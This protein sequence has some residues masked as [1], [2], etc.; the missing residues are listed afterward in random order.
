MLTNLYRHAQALAPGISRL[1]NRR[2]FS[3]VS[4]HQTF[5]ASLYRFQIHRGS[6]L[7]DRALRQDD[8][9]Y[10][11][12][13]EISPDGLVH[14]NITIDFSNGA[15]LM[16][17]TLFMQKV[18]RNSFDYYIDS[19]EGG[20]TPAEPHYLCIPKGTNI[21]KS[22]ILYR[23]RTSRFSLQPA[24]PMSLDNLNKELTEFYLDFGRVLDAD[25][26]LDRNPYN[27][28]YFDDQEDWMNH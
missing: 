16:P 12:G 27:E 19:V 15:V 6:T 8:W 11:D 17:N 28:A 7:Y 1:R 26:W 24:H 20:Q 3:Y 10:E 18:T 21:P 22:L 5:P 25:E 13:I 2:A 23:E 4:T 14:P 9:E